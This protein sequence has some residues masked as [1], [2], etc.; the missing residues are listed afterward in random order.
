MKLKH[1]HLFH[2]VARA[3]FLL[4]AAFLVG[5]GP[6]RAFVTDSKTVT[7]FDTTGVTDVADVDVSVEFTTSTSE[8]QPSA[9]FKNL[10]S[11]QGPPHLV[12]GAAGA[13]TTFMGTEKDIAGG[14]QSWELALQYLNSGDINSLSTITL[15][16]GTYTVNTGNWVGPD[17]NLGTNIHFTATINTTVGGTIGADGKMTGGKHVNLGTL[18]GYLYD[19]A[20]TTSKDWVG[21]GSDKVLS[22]LTITDIV[23]E[24]NEDG[25][26]KAG[27]LPTEGETISLNGYENYCVHITADFTAGTSSVKKL[28]AGFGSIVYQ[29]ETV[30]DGFIWRGT[31][32]NHYWNGASND[33]DKIVTDPKTGKETITQAEIFQSGYNAIFDGQDENHQVVFNTSNAIL[34]AGILITTGEYTFDMQN[35]A[36]PTAKVLNLQSDASQLNITGEDKVLAVDRVVGVG[37]IGKTGEGKTTLQASKAEDASG[38]AFTDFTGNIKV[39]DGV[40]DIQSATALSIEDLILENGGQLE[41][42][43]QIMEVNGTLKGGGEG[44]GAS[45]GAITLA[46]GATL[47][48]SDAEGKGG[49][50]LTGRVTLNYGVELSQNDFD[51]FFP[52]TKPGDEYDLLTV[53]GDLKLMNEAGQII[54]ATELGENYDAA[55]LFPNFTEGYFTLRYD[56]APGSNV[57][58]FYLYTVVPEPATCTL[59]LLALAALAARRRRKNGAC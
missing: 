39:R 13:D 28:G 40:L 1:T 52:G 12:S 11:Q 5:V 20:T 2:K 43:Q 46:S 6:A 7:T 35:G 34:A 10:S 54:N 48:A 4:A 29:S 36:A 32:S 53:T 26:R 25:S 9:Y 57:G 41:V 49:I 23:T 47:D 42:G 8:T 24:W 38:G 33:W 22:T 18:E 17:K 16:L 27:R 59:S 37:T 31:D 55:N 51:I 50:N 45:A 44:T 15:A 56:V 3:S 21:T 19:P 14:K 58:R 30:V